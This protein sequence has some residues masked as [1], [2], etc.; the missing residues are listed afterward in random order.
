MTVCFFAK[1]SYQCEDDIQV[2]AFFYPSEIKL[3]VE[4]LAYSYYDLLYFS[5]IM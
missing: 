1:N 4:D 3:T 5:F 2:V